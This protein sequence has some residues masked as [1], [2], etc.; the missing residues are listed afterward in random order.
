MRWLENSVLS[1]RD[2]FDAFS[3]QSRAG[4]ER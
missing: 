3:D 2:A 4:E 1:W